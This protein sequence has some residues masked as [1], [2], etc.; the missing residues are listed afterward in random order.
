MALIKKLVIFFVLAAVLAVS[1]GSPSQVLAAGDCGDSY[2]V[3]R[4]DYLRKIALLCET[5]V[6]ALE[7]ANPDLQNPN[8]IYPGQ[9]LMLPGAIIKGSGS[10][11]VYI[12]QSG[13]TL[14]KLATR[15]G[16][17][18]NNLLKLNP[19]VKDVSVIYEG[20]RLSV[21]KAGIPVTGGTDIYEV[22]R[23]D[24]LRIIASKF[25]TTVD[26]LLRLNPG[27]KNRN[28]IYVGQK[29]VVPVE[30]N[31]YVVQRGDTLRKIA[32]AFDTTVDDLLELNPQIKNPNM[33]YVGQ[34]IWVP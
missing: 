8:R 7:R 11:D 22:K 17:T 9:I 3:Q 19:D 6:A 33:I 4:G 23:G 15:F 27:I 21:P 14:N 5:T 12:V 32:S 29:L 34:V 16:T 24:T 18:V 28:L 26:E 30:G 10:T 31:T 25:E 2:T 13:D 1:F 20:Q